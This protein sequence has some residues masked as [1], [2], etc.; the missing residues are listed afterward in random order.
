MEIGDKI[1]WRT[2]N[3]SQSGEIVSE[4]GCGGYLVRLA[5]GR[6]VLVFPDYI[7]KRKET[8]KTQSYENTKN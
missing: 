3:G 1:Q 4:Y 8:P 2:A 7:P 5:S 6:C